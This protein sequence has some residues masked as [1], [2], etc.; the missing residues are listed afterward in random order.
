MGSKLITFYALLLL[1]IPVRAQWSGY[2]DLAGGYGRTPHQKY[3]YM[4]SLNHG[5]M[6]LDA[7]LQYENP[8][9][10]WNTTLNGKW[11]PKAT[12]SY[13][14]TAKTVGGEAIIKE[15]M[16]KPLSVGLRSDF[17]WTPAPI[18]MRAA[19]TLP[20]PAMTTA[21]KASSSPWPPT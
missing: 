16:T 3:I 1:A 6:Q 5:M 8:K 7:R 21:A 12:D 10:T 15:R 18:C 11:E 2:V 4:E 19:A 20:W 13:H 17:S 14:V 9:W